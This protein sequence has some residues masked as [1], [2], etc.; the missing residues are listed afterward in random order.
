MLLHWHLIKRPPT[1]WWKSGW[2]YIRY[3]PNYLWGCAWTLWPEHTVTHLRYDTI[4]SSTE[5]L[6][7]PGLWYWEPWCWDQHRKQRIANPLHCSG[8]REML[9][10]FIQEHTVIHIYN[11]SAATLF[12]AIWVRYN[13][14]DTM[15]CVYKGLRTRSFC[16]FGKRRALMCV[17]CVCMGGV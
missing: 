10:L 12:T 3:S 17:L 11:C 14:M 7:L 8:A 16:C 9:L 13:P 4:R 1:S 5:G 15:Y 2:S 6:M